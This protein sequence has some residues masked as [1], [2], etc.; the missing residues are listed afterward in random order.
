MHEWLNGFPGSITVCDE[1]GIIVEMNAKAINSFKKDGGEKLIGTSL[2][3]CHTEPAL[4][5]LKELLQT[6]KRN[7]YTIEKKGVRKI[8]YQSPFFIDG[9]FSGLV[10]LS[11]DIPATMPHFVRE[12]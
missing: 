2:F 1:K 10:E 5:K 9:K 8:I 12:G 4:S 11:L 6:Q 3:D 7:V